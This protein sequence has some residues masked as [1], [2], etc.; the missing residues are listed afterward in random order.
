MSTKIRTLSQ[1]PPITGTNVGENSL[2]EISQR[3]SIGDK[4][5]YISKKMRLH[6]FSTYIYDAVRNEFVNGP[7]QL[8]TQKFDPEGTINADSLVAHTNF[9]LIATALYNLYKGTPKLDSQ[10][11]FNKRPRIA[12]SLSKNLS[13][14]NTQ[15]NIVDVKLLKGFSD[16][17]NLQLPGMEFDFSTYFF[18]PEVE[19]HSLSATNLVSIDENRTSNIRVGT[20]MQKGKAANNYSFGLN[21]FDIKENHY[22]EW[23]FRIPNNSRQSNNWVAPASGMF[24]CF[25]WLDEKDGS[26]ANNSLRWVALEAYNKDKGK[27]YILQLQPF[28]PNEFC[29]YVGFTFPVKAGIELRIRTGF[30]VGTNSDKYFSIIGSLTNHIANAFIGG[31]YTSDA[32]NQY[33]PKESGTFNYFEG[34]PSD[35]GRYWPTNRTVYD[36]VCDLSS[37]LSGAFAGPYIDLVN[38]NPYKRSLK[39]DIEMDIGRY[40]FNGS[41]KN[42]IQLQPRNALSSMVAQALRSL[43]EQNPCG[44][45][46]MQNSRNE[47]Q[48]LFFYKV[49]KTGNVHIQ[50]HDDFEGGRTACMA[51]IA[52]AD[53]TKDGGITYSLKRMNIQIELLNKSDPEESITLPLKAGNLLAFQCLSAYNEAYETEERIDE[54]PLIEDPTKQMYFG[55]ST[56]TRNK[57]NTLATFAWITEMYNLSPDQKDE[58]D[59]YSDLPD[60]EPVT[61]TPGGNDPI[62]I[63]DWSGDVNELYQ[64]IRNLTTTVNNNYNVLSNSIITNVNTLNSTIT[65][66]YNTLNASKVGYYNGTVL[67][68]WRICTMN[69]KVGQYDGMTLDANGN[70]PYTNDTKSTGGYTNCRKIEGTYYYFKPPVTGTYQITLCPENGS[71]EGTVAAAKTYGIVR[72]WL[73]SVTSKKWWMRERIKSGSSWGSWSSWPTDGNRNYWTLLAQYN[74]MISGTDESKTI[75]LNLK[76]GVPLI[77]TMFNTAASFSGKSIVFEGFSRG[78]GYYN[79]KDFYVANKYS[80]HQLEYYTTDMNNQNASTHQT[81]TGSIDSSK[82]TVTSAAHR[83]NNTTSNFEF[84]DIQLLAK[85]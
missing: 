11:T 8:K 19:T 45:G 62:D 52:Y 80:T 79:P 10:I 16:Q 81:V 35:W 4:A 65:N 39:N 76:A 75:V 55:P 38:N 28:S 72:C 17:N 60:I 43:N 77:F 66:N 42:Y 51:Y 68:D 70:M 18:N 2:I 47:F 44:F 5:H 25:G 29:S 50:F 7:H 85:N 83:K 63:P 1:L 57:S 14:L 30:T 21:E 59:F 74:E 22:N 41:S 26:Y 61:P 23:I 15:D 73:N 20:L 37:S 48:K 24:T 46:E 71:A 69:R 53:T 13:E 3:L 64:M 58:Y 34:I 31:V 9:T 12:E 82:V 6:D 78:L 84:A 40:I 27:W 49:T 36:L 56:P 54:Y 32:A 67:A 33:I